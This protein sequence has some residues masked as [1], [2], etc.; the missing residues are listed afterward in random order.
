MVTVS[1][2]T[3]PAESFTVNLNTYSPVCRPETVASKA[4]SSSN[5]CVPGPDTLV[6]FT[7]AIV[8]MQKEKLL[9]NQYIMVPD[10]YLQ[11]K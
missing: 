2:A 1:E 10:Y 4:V 11:N 6:H 5:V 8:L 3:I 9:V 7:S